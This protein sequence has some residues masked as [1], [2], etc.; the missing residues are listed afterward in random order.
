MPIVLIHIFNKY[1]EPYLLLAFNIICVTWNMKISILYSPSIPCKIMSL[2][3]KIL[4]LFHFRSGQ[5][6]PRLPQQNQT[7]A[8]Q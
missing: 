8:P 6:V 5:E 2:F 4:N 1:F 7:W 3:N